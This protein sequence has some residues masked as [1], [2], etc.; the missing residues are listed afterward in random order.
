MESGGLRHS[1]LA[2]Y[3]CLT[4]TEAS[5]AWKTIFRRTVTFKTEKKWKTA[6]FC[7]HFINEKN[8]NT[9]CMY[10]FNHMIKPLTISLG[11]KCIFT[12]NIPHFLDDREE[13]D[14]DKE[15]YL[16]LYIFYSVFFSF[17]SILPPNLTTSLIWC[18]LSHALLWRLGKATSQQ[19]KEDQK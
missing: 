5:E 16:I 8:T 12:V 1:T 11:I 9:G 17:L 6:I 10:I 2:F 7:F 18:H 14:D 19:R 4:A 3:L 15:R 13:K